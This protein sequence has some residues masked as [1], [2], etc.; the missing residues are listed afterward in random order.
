VLGEQ[1]IALHMRHML[2]QAGQTLPDARP[3]LEV[4]LD[5]P[6]VQRLEGGANEQEFDDLA[7]ILHGQAVLSEGGQLEDPAGFVQRLN[8]VMLDT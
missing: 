8:R 2:E 1:E 7:H 3:A 5:H 6:L 4:N